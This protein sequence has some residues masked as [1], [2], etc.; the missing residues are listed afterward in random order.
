MTHL[1]RNIL[2]LWNLTRNEIFMNIRKTAFSVKLPKGL[3]IVLKINSEQK[4]VHF[5]TIIDRFVT[6]GTNY[7]YSE[8]KIYLPL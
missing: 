1:I 4:D 2:K 3:E 5:I 7:G 8:T 6:C